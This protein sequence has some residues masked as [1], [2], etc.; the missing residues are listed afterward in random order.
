MKI[1]KD[2]KGVKPFGSKTRQLSYKQVKHIRWNV[3]YL[4]GEDVLKY[5]FNLFA[6]NKEINLGNFV[7]DLFQEWGFFTLDSESISEKK[8][9]NSRFSY[10]HF[11]VFSNRSP[12]SLHW[13]RFEGYKIVKDSDF[14][15]K[16]KLTLEEYLDEKYKN[17]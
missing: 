4:Q 3:E 8:K 7:S 17:I 11:S 14:N 1:V 12:G 16:G 6:P 9:F 10:Q 2:G 13:N 15:S 5:H